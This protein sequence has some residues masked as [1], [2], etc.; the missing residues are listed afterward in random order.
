MEGRGKESTEGSEDEQEGGDA[1]YSITV[2]TIVITI[3]D[4]NNDE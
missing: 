3:K 4:I 1:C 2:A